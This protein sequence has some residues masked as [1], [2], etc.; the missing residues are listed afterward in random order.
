MCTDSTEL[1]TLSSKVLLSVYLPPYASPL[2]SALHPK[3]PLLSTF[4]VA[5]GRR[6]LLWGNTRRRL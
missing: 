5:R 4:I 2:A 1:L 3:M 6:L